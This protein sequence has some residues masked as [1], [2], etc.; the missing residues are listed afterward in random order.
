MYHPTDGGEL[1]WIEPADGENCHLEVAVSDAADGR[2]VPELDV[3]AR[4]VSEDGTE[5]GPVEVPFVWHPGLHHY[6]VNLSVP[7]D[8]TYAVH[9]HVEPPSFPRHDE[10]NGDRYAEPVDV[11]FEDVDVET[12]RD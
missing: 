6:G 8:G 10:T 7:G 11:T 9:V 1:E 2:F 4:L 5:V 3:S 12:G